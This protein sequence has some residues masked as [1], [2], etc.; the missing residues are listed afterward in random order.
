VTDHGEHL[1][2]HQARPGL[3]EAA[4]EVAARYRPG[5]SSRSLALAAAASLVVGLGGGLLLA[6]QGAPASALQP[7]GAARAVVPASHA[8][9]ME[10]VRL[11]CYAPDAAQVSVAGS[12]NAW[13]VEAAPMRSVGGGLFA[14]E[15]ALPEGRHEYMFVVNGERWVTDPAAPF[16]TDD[17]FG[18][19]NSVIEI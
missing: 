8:S 2:L 16:G 14:V 4:H 12:F 11:V 19:R 17:G 1:L 7:D 13:S 9:S 18:Q 10:P 5:W 15:L 3:V 6:R